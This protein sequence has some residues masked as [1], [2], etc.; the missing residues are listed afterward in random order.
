MQV[1]KLIF[2]TNISSA[3]IFIFF[4]LIIFLALFLLRKM[5]EL[6]NKN[7][8]INDLT[9]SLNTMDE[10]ARLIVRTDLELSHIQ[11]ELDKKI[12]SL[13]A[14][15]RLSE[16]LN[17]YLGEEI[18][19]KINENIVNDLGFDLLAVFIKE[20][21]RIILKAA[22]GIRQP[23]NLFQFEE[24]SN[25]KGILSFLSDKRMVSD[26]FSAEGFEPLH[27]YIQSKLGVK[28]FV[29]SLVHG[30]EGV[31]GFV[32]LGRYIKTEFF[33]GT[34][35]IVEILSAH[36]AQAVDNIRLFEELYSSKKSLE[37]KIKER[38][39]DLEKALKE[40]EKS[41]RLKSEFVSAVSH[42][43]RTPLTSIKGYA[44]LLAQE[45][46]GKMPED[47]KLRLERINQQAD[48]LVN[49]INGFLDI[50]RIESGRIGISFQKSDLSEIIKRV[51][52]NLYPQISG[53]KIRLCY[54]LPEKLVL[55]I[56]RKLM[57]RAI[58][59]LLSNAV[60]FTPEGKKIVITASL[61]GDEAEVHIKDEGIGIRTEDLNNVFKEF[62]RTDAAVKK[63]V[64]GT[65]LG[66]SLVKNIINAHKGSIKVESRLGEGADFIFTLPRMANG[67]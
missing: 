67:K 64:Q 25:K 35:E 63:G 45:K 49:M 26:G 9:E 66:L 57:E 46:F 8:K 13:F 10:Q 21:D 51:G 15:Q 37:D 36:I 7:A 28:S 62:Y 24:L 16:I 4:G 44:S 39:M 38:T 20:G 18:F 54:R 33:E 2:G 19:S 14:L 12:K 43:F 31:L 59:N 61:S 55:D 27:D 23:E 11:E 40:V 3:I 34:R 22:A 32:L 29:L 50:S 53:K 17:R 56:D 48:S 1:L 60:K 58:T 52:E 41:S 30:K 5:E 47:V 6:K 65:G 42:E